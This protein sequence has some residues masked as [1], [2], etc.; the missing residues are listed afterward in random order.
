MKGNGSMEDNYINFMFKK[1]QKTL[2]TLLLQG[3]QV[4]SKLI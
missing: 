2:I 4:V 3:Y 1:K